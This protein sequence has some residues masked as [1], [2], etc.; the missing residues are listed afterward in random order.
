MKRMDAAVAMLELL[1]RRRAE[2]EDSTLGEEIE[3][4]L[5]DTYIRDLDFDYDAAAGM[6]PPLKPWLSKLG[7]LL[8]GIGPHAVLIWLLSSGR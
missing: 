3:R 2:A 1:D 4:D 5:V 6:D 7:F 8:I